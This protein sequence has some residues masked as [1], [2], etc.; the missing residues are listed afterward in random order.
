MDN[1][2]KYLEA[3]NHTI[4]YK[5]HYGTIITVRNIEFEVS[6]REKSKRAKETDSVYESYRMVPTGTLIFKTRGYPYRE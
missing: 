2:I 3:R 4:G 1:L 5:K 6:L